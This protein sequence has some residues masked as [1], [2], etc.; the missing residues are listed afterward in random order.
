MT[1]LVKC[2]P[3][4]ISGSVINDSFKYYKKNYALYF[5]HLATYDSSL[6]Q[7]IVTQQLIL[8]E[9]IKNASE[10]LVCLKSQNIN[11]YFF[12]LVCYS[13]FSSLFSFDIVDLRKSPSTDK[14]KTLGI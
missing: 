9:I 5:P 8:D 1:K 12:L 7:N 11:L 14:G 6:L 3:V 13:V 10:H 2:H 4:R